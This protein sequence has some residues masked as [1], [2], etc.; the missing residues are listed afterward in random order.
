[1]AGR[2][3]LSLLFAMAIVLAPAR[4][5]ARPCVLINAPSEKACQPVCCAN[6]TC[7]ATSPKNTAP[8]AQPLAKSGFGPELNATGMPLFTAI[9]PHFA[10]APPHFAGCNAV[11]YAHSPPQLAALCTFLI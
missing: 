10:P 7:C 5:S 6:K 1:M 9:N 3:A 2:I 4:L 8:V 11:P